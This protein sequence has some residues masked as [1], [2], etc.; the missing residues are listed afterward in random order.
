MAWIS[1]H[2][3]VV[4][5]KLRSLAKKIGCSQN[6]ALGLLVRFWLWGIHNASP[7]GR[8]ESATEEDIAD[9]LNIG[10]DRRYQAKDVVAA[11]IEVGWIDYDEGCLFIHDWKEWQKQWYKAL[12][13]RTFDNERKARDREKRAVS[14][15]APASTD[16]ERS[17]APQ[18][19][20]SSDSRDEKPTNPTPKAAKKATND[21]PTGFEEF[22]RAYPKKV[23]K[24]E[25]YKCYQARLKDGWPPKELLE[26]ATEYAKETDRRHT[27][28][29]FIKHPKTF[30]SAATPFTDYIPSRQKVGQNQ[31]LDRI[32]DNW[33]D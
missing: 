18:K 17:D 14:E 3:Q 29:E 22:W 7:E 10:I 2:E 15:S 11:M 20:D 12:R 1:V 26:A 25:A 28:Q 21:Y 8:I 16:K 5:G 19:A 6:E 13:I 23:G 33:R 32:Y 9:V 30:L 27:K 31:D 4:G 24:G